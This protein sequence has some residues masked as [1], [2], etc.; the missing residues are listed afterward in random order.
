MKGR[1]DRKEQAGKTWRNGNVE[2][3]NEEGKE[4]G[5]HDPRHRNQSLSAF[6]EITRCPSNMSG[7][8]N[9]FETTEYGI[10]FSKCS[11]NC[12]YLQ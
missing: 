1:E 11:V 5:K 8:Q 2:R 9:M 7:L 3:E 6:T 10:S 4:R 12:V